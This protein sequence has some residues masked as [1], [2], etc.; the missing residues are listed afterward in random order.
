MNVGTGAADGIERRIGANALGAHPRLEDLPTLPFGRADQLPTLAGG[1][2]LSQHLRGDGADA[3]ALHL[4]RLERDAHQHGRQRGYLDG[5]VPAVH[6]GGGI[7]LGDADRAG[8]I[9]GRVKALAAFHALKQQIGARVEDAVEAQQLDG[10][11]RPAEQRE[12]RRAVHDCRF[13]QEALA[14]GGGLFG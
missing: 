10:R 3:L 12:D 11:Q 9:D 2:R 8:V 5:G 4:L 7:G 13:E 6:V 14:V 1:A